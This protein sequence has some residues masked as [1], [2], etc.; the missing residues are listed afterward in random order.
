MPG[1]LN[2][3]NIRGLPEEEAQKRLLRDGYNELPSSKPR[4]IF[5]ITFDVVREPMFLLLVACGVI[6]LL[7]GDVRDASLLLGFVFVVMGITLYQE[8]RTERALEALR[9]LSSPRALVI[10]DG[11]QKR[12]A[13]RDVV[14]GDIVMLAEGDRVPADAVLFWSRNLTTDES[15][16]TGESQAVP[17]IANEDITS[18]A[19]PCGDNT[20]F[21]YSG[22]LI[23]QGQGVGRVEAVAFDTELGKIGKSLQTLH[24]QR[25]PLQAETAK[26]VRNLAIIGLSLC[27]IVVVAYSLAQHNWSDGFL[28]GLTLA[29]SILPEELPVILTIF[30]AIGAW[31]MSQK[32]VLARRIPVVETLGAATVL[33]VDKT[34]TLTMNQMSVGMVFADGD[35]YDLRQ[36]NVMPLPEKFHDVLEYGILAS[37]RNPFDP[38]E[39]ALKQYGDQN[40]SDTEHLHHDWNVV[41][42]YPLSHDLLALSYVWQDKQSR[43]YVIAAKGAPEAIADLCHLN[44]NRTADIA[45]KVTVMTNEGMRVLGIAKTSFKERILPKQQH[46]FEF[47]FVGLVAL[48]DP[49]RPQVPDAVRECYKAGI[50]II[51]ITGDH[52][53]TARSIARQIELDSPDLFITGPELDKMQDNQLQERIKSVN[54]FAR[55]I[56]EQK[57]QLVKALKANGEIVAMTGDGVNDAPALKSA[58]IGVAMGARGTDVAREA[59][60]LVL[61]DDN[62]S[63]IEQAVKIGRQIYDNIKKAVVY[64][65]AIHVPIAG[66]SLIPVLMEWPLVLLPVHIVFLELIIDPACSIVFEAEPPESDIMNRPPRNPKQPL[67]NKRMINMSLLQGFSVLGVVLAVFIISRYMNKTAELAR[68]LTFTTL[69]F[70]NLGLIMV[71][72]SWSR[73]ILSTLRVPNTAFWWVSSA[74]VVLLALVLYVPFLEAIFKFAS[75]NAGELLICFALG[76]SGALWFGFVKLLKKQP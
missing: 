57:L 50:R 55:V 15:L 29:M 47:T 40:L 30:L 54:I 4:S 65:F 34:G 2:I 64:T 71:N 20:P 42:E 62:F 36:K 70:A 33:C 45:E 6:Y 22:T 23:V 13:G 41:Q 19:R 3:E 26:M 38:T 43:D 66:M 51:M 9:N 73:T 75:P 1:D 49:V 14:K 32:H 12:I 60:S 16:L 52:P 76:T 68:A 31:R 5:A 72:R 69:I 10:R 8:R 37:K 11:L 53:G 7:M 63:S 56:P 24:L 48:A 17:K 25:T 27:I 46:D 59:A 39:K 21:V 28:A 18:I 44:E 61:L 74:A 58:H 35:F 67:F